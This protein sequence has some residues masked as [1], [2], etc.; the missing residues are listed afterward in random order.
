MVAR[1]PAERYDQRRRVMH[2]VEQVIEPAARIGRRP[3]V[4][5]GLHPRYPRPRPRRS[6]ISSAAIQRRVLRHYSLL[7]LSQPLPPFPMCRAHPGP[8]YYGG[9]A[10]SRAGQPT[11]GSARHPR[12]GSARDRAGPGGSRVHCDS[13]AEGGAQLY[14]CGIATATPQHFTVAS[15]AGTRSPARKFPAP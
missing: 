15:R 8:E 1:D 10:P 13:P 14:P 5:L 9:S 3:T 11:A 4:K 2:E 6:P 7:P 12:A